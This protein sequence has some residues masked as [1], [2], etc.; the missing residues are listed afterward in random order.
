MIFCLLLVWINFQASAFLPSPHRPIRHLPTQGSSLSFSN[1]AL[2]NKK[3][4][5]LQKLPPLDKDTASPL[6]I[7]FREL[8]EGIL[9]T[10]QEIEAITNPRLR[11]IYEGIEASYHE[12]AVYRA[13]EVLYE[14]YMPLRVAGRMV[15]RKMKNVM[16]ACQA[17]QKLQVDSVVASTGLPLDQVLDSW[18]AFVRLA[19]GREITIE[20][21]KSDLATPLRNA[22]GFGTESDF[23]T[24]LDPG[25]KGKLSFEEFVVGL[26]RCVSEF[27]PSSGTLLDSLQFIPESSHF[28]SEADKQRSKL[29]QRYDEMLEKFGEWKKFIPDGEGRRL[30]ILRGCF[31]GSENPK[32]VEA[33]RVIYVDFPPLRMSGD[34]IFRVVSTIMGASRRGQN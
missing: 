4:E 17:D 18:S 6:Q 27:A 25:L 10:P 33:L 26:Q 22:L 20:Q 1:V 13:F 3:Q 2:E 31:V 7:E 8:L 34:W 23:L 24:R 12:P 19:K 14:D 32:V 11:A 21:V 16:E 30:D 28:Y 9:Y 15:Y 5:L 29:N